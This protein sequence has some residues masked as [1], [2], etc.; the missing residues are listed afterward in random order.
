VDSA[1]GSLTVFDNIT[2]S[3]TYDI[4]TVFKDPDSH[5][6][7]TYSLV[8]YP[9]FTTTTLVG[10]TL[11]VSGIALF[12]D[13]G[14]SFEVVISASDSFDFQNDQLTIVVSENSPP[15]EPSTFSSTIIGY[16]DTSTT[17]IVEA[18]TDSD[19]DD[20]TYSME[21]SDSSALDESWITFDP[22]TLELIFTPTV[23][24]ASP[25]YLSLIAQDDHN[26]PVTSTITINIRYKPLDNP[27]VVDRV[28]IF[29]CLSPTV[30]S[31]TRNIIT[32]DANI[33]DYQV[34]QADGSAI[35]PWISIQT[36]LESPSGNFEANGTY[37][38]FENTEIIFTV[39]ATDEHGLVGTANFS[40][41]TK[42]K[43]FQK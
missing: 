4:S 1:L 21:F 42:C 36:P 38:T 2:F 22:L 32:D 6:I 34:E 29:I 7:L 23:S 33:V 40:I 9:P 3:N 28:G 15:S 31:L 16:E 24:I 12:S 13:I 30:Y 5:H 27:A 8:S 10:T 26:D 20:I 19:G 41:V 14:G 25:V 11:S 17:H 35:P 43:F 37:P 39:T 18:F